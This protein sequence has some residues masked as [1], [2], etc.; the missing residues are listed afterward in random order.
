MAPR[1]TTPQPDR[2]E[3]RHQHPRCDGAK[4]AGG[5]QPPPAPRLR[6]AA[7]AGPPPAGP[8]APP[9]DR[10]APGPPGQTLDATA[11]VHEAYLRV[12]GG[13]PGKPWQ[14]RAHFFAAAAE[15]MRRILVDRARRKARLKHGGGRAR[16]VVEPAAL[17]AR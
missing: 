6:R 11:L 17:P 13:D 8:P 9:P 1:E 5:C 3:R 2:H 12:V 7:A 10:L 4:R 14:G 16:A 15:A